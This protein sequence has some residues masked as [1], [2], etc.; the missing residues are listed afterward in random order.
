[1]NKNKVQICNNTNNTDFTGLLLMKCLYFGF[2]LLFV[3]L[4]NS[5]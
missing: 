1:M 4:K 2:V 5:G 3:N